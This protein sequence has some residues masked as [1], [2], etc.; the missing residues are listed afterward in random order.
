MKTI[1]FS[2]VLVLFSTISYSQN[3]KIEFESGSF[4]DLKAKAKKENKIIFIDAYTTWCGPCKWMD[5]NIFTNDTVAD[6]F[7]STFVNAKIDM[8]KG[9]GLEIAKN[10]NVQCYPTY[11]FL[12]ADGNMLHRLAGSRSV[13]EF[14]QVAKD[15]QDPNIRFSH[16]VSGFETKKSDAN[17]LYD[18][19][20]AVAG[21]CLNYDEVKKAYFATQKESELSNHRNWKLIYYYSND[22]FA[23]EMKYFLN[24]LEEFSK[25]HTEDSVNTKL[26]DMLTERARQFAYSKSNTEADFEAFKKQIE[27]WNFTSKE[28]A[29]FEVNMM[30]Y[31]VKKDW[32]KYAE[33][34]SQ[35][36]EKFLVGI[37]EINSVA[38]N[39]YEKSDNTE[40]LKKA[41]GWMKK[42]L[43]T[44]ATSDDY[45]YYDTYA[46]LH[47][48]L[49]NK[50]EAKAAAEKAIQLAKEG[51][52]NEE[53]YKATV[54]LLKE[55][56]KLK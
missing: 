54:D 27:G 6:Y 26:T 42:E 45:P 39:L 11:L 24:H 37:S 4:A 34:A 16:F 38:W 5:K 28:K 25:L 36:G 22:F 40:A 48:K 9:E 51:E 1:I 19:I 29:I 33:T 8:E 20:E 14:V 2:F 49:K 18:Y 23:D 47:Y 43:N 55:I 32:A 31:L 46:A 17:F 56:E 21:T 52:M 13:S 7:N 53:D 3:R 41:A 50:K 44:K 30:Y 10:Y 35:G 12:D 15:A